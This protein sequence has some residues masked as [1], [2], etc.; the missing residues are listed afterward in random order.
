MLFWVFFFFLLALLHNKLTRLEYKISAFGEEI[1]SIAFK[2]QKADLILRDWVDIK[3]RTTIIRPSKV[4]QHFLE[5]TESLP[6]LILQS[7]LFGINYE[8][9]GKTERGIYFLSALASI[10]AMCKAIYMYLDVF[11]TNNSPRIWLHMRIFLE[12]RF[13]RFF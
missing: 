8:T 11:K 13:R 3:S 4:D 5:L 12:R 2:K 6:Q 10:I 7:I 1:T 9:S